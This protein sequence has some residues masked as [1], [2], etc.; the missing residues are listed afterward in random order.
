MTIEREALTDG[1][2]FSG[3]EHYFDS[4]NIFNTV[5][6][7]TFNQWVRVKT[8]EA[9]QVIAGNDVFTLSTNANRFFTVIYNGVTLISTQVAESGVAYYVSFSHDNSAAGKITIGTESLSPTVNITGTVGV[10]IAAT[11]AMIY[12]NDNLTGVSLNGYLT[13]MA[14]YPFEETLTQIVNDWTFTKAK[15]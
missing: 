15:V 12:G 4:T 8:T 6:A 2:D 11:T 3:Q 13:Q 9:N 1:Y 14:H 7:E 10:G 5:N